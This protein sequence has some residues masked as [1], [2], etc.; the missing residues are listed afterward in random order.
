MTERKVKLSIYS[1]SK[2][3]R[4]IKLAKYVKNELIEKVFIEK[5]KASRNKNNSKI[6]KLNKKIK[7]HITQKVRKIKI[8][9]FRK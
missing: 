9:D 6:K 4:D 8:N 3:N 2:D 5:S 1:K 7:K